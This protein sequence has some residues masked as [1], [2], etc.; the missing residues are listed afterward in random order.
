MRHLVLLTIAGV[1]L[2]SCNNDPEQTARATITETPPSPSEEVITSVYDLRTAIETTG[3]T[4]DAW[5]PATTESAQERAHCTDAVVL[6]IYTDLAQMEA[7]VQETASL[8]TQLGLESVHL[9]GDDWSINCGGDLDLCARF[10]RAIGGEIQTFSPDDPDE[11]DGY[12]PS[13]DDFMLEVKILEQ[14]CFGS[15]GCL[16]RF[17]VELT[18]LGGPNY[19]DLDPKAKYELTYRID[20]GEDPY[21]NTL[22][23]QSGEYVQD[24]RQRI[25]TVSS[26]F[27]LHAEVLDVVER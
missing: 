17:R 16:V 18:H 25:S 5:E 3:Y 1:A 24:D 20:G 12:V 2:A 26:D 13:A 19:E 27:E 8:A 14:E 6:S 10:S 21:I 4:C 15:A 7:A 9:V 22:E 23:I 11:N